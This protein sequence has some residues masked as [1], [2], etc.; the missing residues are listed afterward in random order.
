MQTKENKPGTERIHTG[1]ISVF[2]SD[3]LDCFHNMF[4]G[5]TVVLQHLGVIMAAAAE[6]ILDSHKFDGVGF[7]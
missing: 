5:Q 3:G 4:F 7:F 1:Q 2:G 6:G